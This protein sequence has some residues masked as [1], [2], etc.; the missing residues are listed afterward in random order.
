MIRYISDLLIEGNGF[1]DIHNSKDIFIKAIGPNEV[2]KTA[3]KPEWFERHK[4]ELG[5]W[6]EEV[7]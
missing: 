4:I 3:V 1:G 6:G 2:L 7:L 5:Y